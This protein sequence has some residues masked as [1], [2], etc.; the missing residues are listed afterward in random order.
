MLLPIYA[1]TLAR[2]PSLSRCTLLGCHPVFLFWYRATA[3][4]PRAPA[5]HALALVRAWPC[6]LCKRPDG[7][8]NWL[9]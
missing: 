7:P 9:G 2:E 8:W 5:R 3:A 4:P 1:E 6:P